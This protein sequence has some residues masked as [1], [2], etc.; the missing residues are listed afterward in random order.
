MKK[1]ILCVLLLTIS[2]L[3]ASAQYRGAL[4]QDFDTACASTTGFPPD[5]VAY[6]PIS[7]TITNGSWQCAPT[8]GR[9]GTPGMACTGT[10]AGQDHLDTALLVSPGLNLSGYT[11]NIYLQFDSKTTNI[12][13]AGRLDLIVS[14]DST[15]NDSFISQDSSLDTSL[16]PVINEDDSTGWVTHRVNLTPYKSIVPLYVAF[17][18]TSATTT[19][20]TW[21]L[22]NINTTIFPAGISK[23]TKNTLPLTVIGNSTS[24]QISF[25]YTTSLSGIYDLVIYDMVGHKVY[26]A[27]M[28]AQQGKAIY[29]IDGLSLHSGMYLIKMGNGLVYGTTKTIVP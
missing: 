26:E 1:H 3:A 8:G 9:W 15:I 4:V 5:W 21:Y 2:A 14:F 10:W 20:S 18:Y 25:S 6:N 27:D 11:G 7:S 16:N 17:M 22:D 13:V 24:S 19:G 29:T 28:N 12:Y 23:I